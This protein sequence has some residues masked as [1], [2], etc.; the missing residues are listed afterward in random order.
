MTTDQQPQPP[1][2]E[3]PELIYLPVYV[4]SR[5][6]V[7]E[8]GQM[9]RKLRARGVPITS[10]WIDEDGEG[11]TAD[12]TELWERIV[13]EIKAAHFLVLYAEQNDFPLKGALIEAGIALGMGKPVIVCLPN[14]EIEARSC[15]P[16]G[17]W[18]HHSLVERNNN[19]ASAVCWRSPADLA[20]ERP[21]PDE[22][23]R[24]R[25]M[26]ERL[27]NDQSAQPTRDDVDY[28][29]SLL[30]RQHTG[31][32]GRDAPE[33]CK[34]VAHNTG[35]GW[36]LGVEDREGEEVA[37]LAWPDVWPESMTGAALHK[38]GFDIL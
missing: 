35:D 5:A 29:L 15:R 36:Y 30:D 11:Q 3:A 24:L 13:S 21:R 10:S 17:S 19:V 6:S 8:R 9:W 7:P 34:L 4:A 22:D 16:I 23:E 14:V 27:T 33:G 2:T 32:E 37:Q 26:R 38:I 31:K 25:K 18:I 28:L 12:F 20:A 1:Q